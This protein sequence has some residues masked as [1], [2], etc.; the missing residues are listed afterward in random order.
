MNSLKKKKKQHIFLVGSIMFK[1]GL[2][3]L[4]TKKNSGTDKFTDKFYEHLR[5]KE[6]QFYTNFSRKVKRRESF[7]THSMRSVLP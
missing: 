4:P 2:A 3:F 7:L 5:K 1:V 6:Y